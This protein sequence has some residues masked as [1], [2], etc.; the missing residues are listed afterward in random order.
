MVLKVDDRRTVD[1]LLVAGT[2]KVFKKRQIH[3][4]AFIR[5]IAD[6]VYVLS[7]TE[8]RI[9]MLKERISR[10]GHDHLRQTLT[11]SRTCFI[12]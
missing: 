4:V 3:P 11:A 9:Q 2:D 6:F 1:G 7:I 10:Y 5:L 8:K 12:S